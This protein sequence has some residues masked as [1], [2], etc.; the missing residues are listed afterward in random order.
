M[1][2]LH[3]LSAASVNL[4]MLQH[5]LITPQLRDTGM[6]VPLGSIVKNNKTLFSNNNIT[7]YIA[8]FDLRYKQ[9]E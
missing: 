3:S 5:V 6:G 2:W 7:K 8:Q 4:I 9:P 1:F